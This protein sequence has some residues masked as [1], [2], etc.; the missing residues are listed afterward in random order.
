VREGP[1]KS[2]QLFLSFQKVLRMLNFVA[3]EV[4][5][6]DSKMF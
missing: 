3:S 1:L 6:N 4:I 5:S 2:S